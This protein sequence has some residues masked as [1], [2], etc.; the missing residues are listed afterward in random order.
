M[1]AL[2]GLLFTGLAIFTSMALATIVVVA[3]RGDRVADGAARHARAAR[4][5]HRHGPHPVPRSPPARAGARRLGAAGAHRHAPAGRLAGHGR[6]RARRARGPGAA[7]CSRRTRARRRCRRTLAPVA[8]APDRARVPRRAD[9]AVLVVTGRGLDRAQPGPA[10]AR[11]A[12]AG[13]HRRP[14]LRS[15][16]TGARR[17]HRGRQRPDARPRRRRGGATPSPQL[18]GRVTPTAA[19]GRRRAPRRSSPATPPAARTSRTGC[20]TATPLVIALRARPGVPAAVAAFR[21]PALA[22]AVIGAEPGLGGRRLRRARGG[23][24]ARLGRGRCSAS[25]ARA[26][27]P[28]GCRC[29]RS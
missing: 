29:S 21:S 10:G 4:R 28:T 2:A 9:D 13:G 15:A 17:S 6:L 1:V 18:R 12:R 23:L 25:R 8:A 26:P 22:A 16:S 3:D 27:W 19:A 11:R 24:P 5:P 7:S 20:A 14:R